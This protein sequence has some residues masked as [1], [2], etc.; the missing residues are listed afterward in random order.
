MDVLVNLFVNGVSTGML[1][2]LLAAGLSLIFGLMS[3]LNFAHGGLFAWGAF[4][5]VWLFNMTSSYVLALIGAILMGMFLGFVLERFLIRPVYGN[6]VRQ[7]L[8][9]LGGMLVLSECIK[10]FWG[11]NPISAKLPTWLQGSL[12]FDGIILIKYR[13]FVIIVGVLIYIGLML[14]LRKTKI[15]LMIRAGVIDKEMVQ[16]LGINIKAIFSFVFLLG[17]GMAALGGFLLAPYSGVIFAEMGM[18]YAILAF[19]V[20]IIGGLGS[21]QGSAIASLIVGLAGAFT[22][23]YLP[24]LSLAINMLMLLFFL[25]VKPTGL[26][27]E[28]G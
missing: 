17:A 4:T 15:G 24:D 16:A 7:L 1:I 20:V 21:V 27:G 22:A 12:T 23:Y 5:G 26:V 2:F 28:K 3:V 19:I 13:L 14:L 11:P 18:Q 9:T 10:V 25:V 8:V 6:H